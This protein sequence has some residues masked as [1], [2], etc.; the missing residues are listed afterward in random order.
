MLHHTGERGSP[1]ATFWA[2]KCHDFLSQLGK[3]PTQ[4]SRQKVPCSHRSYVTWTR[5]QTDNTTYHRP[6]RKHHPGLVYAPP[7]LTKLASEYRRMLPEYAWARFR[8]NQYRPNLPER[9]RGE[10]FWEISA[11]FFDPFFCPVSPSVS[12]AQ[13]SDSPRSANYEYPGSGSALGPAGPGSEVTGLLGLSPQIS[14]C[15]ACGAIRLD[16]PTPGRE[17][18]LALQGVQSI[19]LV[20]GL[21]SFLFGSWYV[22]HWASV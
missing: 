7:L 13:L 6:T 11:Q 1:G 20:W 14:T 16:T 22:T 4:D 17:L 10:K 19:D 2:T 12:L 21:G 5:L 8:K 9:A 18:G 15:A 3:R